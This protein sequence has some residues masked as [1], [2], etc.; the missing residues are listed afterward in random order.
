MMRPPLLGFVAALVLAG[1]A[2]AQTATMPAQTATFNGSTRGYFFTSPSNITI[3]GVQVLL[4]TGSANTFQN[5]AIV[6]FT[7]NTP[8]PNF[9]TTTNAFTQLALGLDLPQGAFQPVNVA[10]AAGDLIGVYGNTMAA[11]G[12]TSGANSYA[13]GSPTTVI[14]G[15]VVALK[16]TGMQFHL[17]SATSPGGMHDVWSEAASTNITRVEFT[18]TV[19][20]APTVYC[21]AKINSLGCTPTIGFT[22]TPSATAGTGFVVNG[23]NV[24]NNKSGLLFYGFSG[25]AALPFQGGTLCVATPIKR[26][27]GLDS[28]GNPPP[29]DCSGVYS[30]DMNAFAVQA[31]PPV[32]PPELTTPGTVVNCQFWGRDQGFAPPNNTTLSDGLEYTVGP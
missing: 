10:V 8:P 20:S 19:G 23:S 18:Y 7:G 25:Q 26:T 12:L 22:G 31:G 32:P 27:Q 24:I 28:G 21:T 15:N 9:P 1:S 29:N 4:Q 17:G 11:A 2:A 30:I 3:T 16:R 5:F 13:G 6:H 14:D